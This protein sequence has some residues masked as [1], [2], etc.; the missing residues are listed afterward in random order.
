MKITLFSIRD[1]KSG[2]HDTFSAPNAEHATRSFAGC[3]NTPGNFIHDFP[4]DFSLYSVGVFDSSTG[5]IDG[6]KVPKFVTDAVS[7]V[8]KIEKKEDNSDEKTV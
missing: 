2:F 1:V 7:L 5:H 6:F 4:E 8:S 3:V